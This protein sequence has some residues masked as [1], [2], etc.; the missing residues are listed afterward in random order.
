MTSIHSWIGLGKI[1]Q[2]SVVISMA[3]IFSWDMEIMIPFECTGHMCQCLTYYHIDFLTDGEMQTIL[4]IIN[5]V[6]GLM[7]LSK[8]DIQHNL[9]NYV[10]DAKPIYILTNDHDQW[11]SKKKCCSQYWYLLP[12]LRSRQCCQGQ[13]TNLEFDLD[14]QMIA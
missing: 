12:V 1:W 7:P 14:Q 6:V 2:H 10:S 13:V 8:M 11:K 4:F 3:H 9:L 5:F